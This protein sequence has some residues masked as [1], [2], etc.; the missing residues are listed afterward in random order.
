MEN[1]YQQAL[2]YYQQNDFESAVS[3]LK[4]CEQSAKVDMLYRECIKGAKSQFSYI[5]NEAQRTNDVLTL[6]EYVQKYLN[7]VGQDDYILQFVG[8]TV[9]ENTDWSPGLVK[10]DQWLSGVI[11]TFLFP[12]IKKILIVGFVMTIIFSIINQ[13]YGNYE[14]ADLL[15]NGIYVYSFFITLVELVTGLSLAYFIVRTSKIAINLQAICYGCL[16]INATLVLYLWYYTNLHEFDYGEES[17]YFHIGAINNILALFVMLVAYIKG[18]NFVSKKWVIPYILLYHLIG[19]FVGLCV[20]NEFDVGEAFTYLGVFIILLQIVYIILFVYKANN[21]ISACDEYKSQMET[22]DDDTEP[23]YNQ[24]IAGMELKYILVIFA[25]VV[26]AI[27]LYL[28]YGGHNK[29]VE[30]APAEDTAV[31]YTEDETQ[32]E[33][34]NSPDPS[35]DNFEERLTADD[36]FIY[37]DYNT[38]YVFFINSQN[39]LMAYSSYKDKI[40]DV[41]EILDQQM[42]YEVIENYSVCPDG[43]GF[44]LGINHGGAH[45]LQGLYHIQPDMSCT[46]LASYS[47]VEKEP[48]GYVAKECINYDEA[49]FDDSIDYI[50]KETYYDFNGKIKRV[51]DPRI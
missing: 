48:D 10:M 5:I 4:Q 13:I 6:N 38:H 26:L 21:I 41:D 16:L 36:Q 1:K 40:F 12:N 50:F 9:Q 24:E 30:Q 39:R 7:V 25:V 2:S 14:I 18:E 43:N 35:L 3:C 47:R 20:I 31:V 37:K 11:D 29:M 51:V 45:A 42:E 17:Y 34:N 8:S 28:N 27:V 44:L 49:R 22:L 33:E 23:W 15:G 32:V 46:C 19:L